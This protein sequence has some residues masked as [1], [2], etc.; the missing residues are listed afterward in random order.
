MVLMVATGCSRLVDYP[1]CGADADCEPGSV[2][3]PAHECKRPCSSDA[4][5]TPAEPRCVGG[6]CTFGEVA[7]CETVDDCGASADACAGGACSCSGGA[8]CPPGQTCGPSG[9]ECPN[10]A[11]VCGDYCIPAEACC[12]NLS[13]PEL[14]CTEG[15]CDCGGGL[16]GCT[17]DCVFFA[18]CCDTDGD[19]PSGQDCEGGHCCQEDRAADET[20]CLDRIDND[21]DGTVDCMDGAD[22]PDGSPCR[23][24]GALCA[25]LMCGHC[26]PGEDPDQDGVCNDRDCDDQ[27]PHCALTCIDAD[28][29]DWCVDQDCDETSAAC[30]DD[31]TDSDGDDLFDCK[32]PCIG[33]GCCTP[34]GSCDGNPGAPCWLG[35]VGCSKDVGSCVD[36]GPAP[37]GDPCETTRVCD[38]FGGCVDCV[39]GAACDADG[40]A[41]TRDVMDC[42]GTSP[43]C[44]FAENLPV[45][46]P[47]GDDD[48][49]DGNG[50]CV[51][52]VE[53]LDCPQNPGAPCTL[54][55][56]ACD[57]VE[58]ADST[59]YAAPGTDCGV[60]KVCDGFG[61]C[62]DCDA[63]AACDTNPGQPCWYGA[64]ECTGGG[65]A[66]GN[67]TP[68][69]GGTYCDVDKICDGIGNCIDCVD[70]SDCDA[71]DNA[72]THDVLDCTVA[73][74]TCDFVANEPF[75]TPC[76]VDL[77]CNDSGACVCSP[78]EDCSNAIDDDCDS[79]TDCA[80]TDCGGLACDDG[81]FCTQTDVCSGGT[82]VGGGNPCG[83]PSDGD[84]AACNEDTDD[85][86]AQEPDSST[87]GDGVCEACAGGVCTPSGAGSESSCPTCQDCNGAGACANVAT[88][89][90]DG[91]CLSPNV[92]DSTG[93][94]CA[95][96]SDGAFCSRHGKNCGSFSGTDNC[97][98]AR[99]ANCGASCGA[100]KS[101]VSNVCTNDAAGSESTCGVCQDCNSSGA[102]ANVATG[103]TDV[104]CASPNVCNGGSCCSPE[105]DAAFCARNGKNCG[106]FSGTDNCGVARTADC[107]ASCGACKSCVSNVCTNDAAGS[108]ST[109]GVCQDCNSGGACANV[110]TGQTDVGCASPNVCNGGS[111][112]TPETDAAFCSRNGKNCGSYSGTDNCGVARTASCGSCGD[113]VCETCVSNVCTNDGAGAE[114]SCATCQDCNGSGACTNVGNGQTDVG[115]ASPNLCNGGSCCTPE[116]NAAFCARH[117]K[118]CGSFTGTDNCGS[119]RTT[120][121]GSCGDGICEYCSSNV[122]T[123]T[124]NG[125]L[126]NGCSADSNQCTDDWCNGSGSC[127]HPAKTNGT[128]CDDGTICTSGETCQG[129][130]CTPAA[131][132]DGT[133]SW[134]D[135][136]TMRFT[137]TGAPS[138]TQVHAPTW[139][140]GPASNPQGDIAWVPLNNNGGGNWSADYTGFREV[141]AFTTHFYANL[142]AMCEA[143]GTSRPQAPAPVCTMTAPAHGATV[144]HGSSVTWTVSCNRQIARVYWDPWTSP[145]TPLA[146]A[147]YTTASNTTGSRTH[148]LN[149]YALY[150]WTALGE[151]DWGVQAGFVYSAVSACASNAGAVCAY[152]FG[153]RTYDL[154]TGDGVFGN[155]SCPSD[156]DGWP[157]GWCTT[158]SCLE[159]N[160]TTYFGIGAYDHYNPGYYGAQGGYVGYSCLYPWPGGDPNYCDHPEDWV[161]VTCG[162]LVH[163]TRACDGTCVPTPYNPSTYPCND[164]CAG[165][166]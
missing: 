145:Y 101:C 142:A 160:G 58:C 166:P 5:C 14:A 26:P 37:F 100:C 65:P 85:C 21:C 42:S 113:G 13:C 34:G 8:R 67:G 129:G 104:G 118:N 141:G 12:S 84:C 153:Q 110:T 29:D 102:C 33:G 55:K 97:G 133:A 156:P 109:C 39:P 92:C 107:G 88:G 91:G 93:G 52:C 53:G 46:D 157:Y 75:D 23:A 66:C 124:T 98:V 144:N 117:G 87:C 69:P 147:G 28:A 81:L 137:V 7:E 158:P 132:F 3:T 119:S 103:Q 127:V 40:L 128:G 17:A 114:S 155:D 78:S 151:D 111:C 138:A 63:G 61:G 159:V 165:H 43:G 140:N 136:Y 83:P 79:A 105:T 149:G 27:K 70:G 4:D 1:V 161:R 45:G 143:Q 73:P 9:C 86:S 135:P 139:G 71:D 125:T 154:V 25:G 35:T 72:C 15:A 31:C 106:S 130:T 108:E 68:A 16:P 38:G 163:G 2:C 152:D 22:C 62:V 6:Y 131:T 126:A 89:T 49:C 123:N 112:C 64:I 51:P 122:C 148:T 47:C 121:C 120:D 20:S 77:T 134:L 90:S 60:D 24:N 116:S 56:T 82:C 96:E 50:V 11:S 30:T 80:D 19:C 41:C 76:G 74:P 95:P 146:A 115:C 164:F 36:S 94:C 32:D 10:G 57:P 48:M 54:G 18:E 59:T 150:G 162:V 99:T 44:V